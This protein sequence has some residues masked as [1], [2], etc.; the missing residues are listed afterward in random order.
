MQCRIIFYY[1]SSIMMED[2]LISFETLRI[3]ST[4]GSIMFPL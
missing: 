3:C 4:V 1:I 2:M